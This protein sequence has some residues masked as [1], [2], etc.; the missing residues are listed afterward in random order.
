MMTQN[1]YTPLQRLHTSS[2]LAQTKR[3]TYDSLGRMLTADYPGKCNGQSQPE[4]QQRYDQ[5]PTG[6]VCPLATGCIHTNRLVY[7]KVSLLCS[8][9]YPYGSLDQETFYGYDFAGRLVE[10]YIRDDS[11]RIASHTYAWDKNDN[12][13]RVTLPSSAVLGTTYGSAAS[14]SDAD[15]PAALWRTSPAT[16]IIDNIQWNPGGV[17]KQYNRFDT[18]AG[19]PLRMKI[20]YNQGSRPTLV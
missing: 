3:F 4:I 14:N 16:P 9:A 15:R 8:A 17:L 6:M 19:I 20:E 7:S 1:S 10:E 13:T 18:I 5:T 11:G 2:S 12:L